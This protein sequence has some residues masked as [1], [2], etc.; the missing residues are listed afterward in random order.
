MDQE[1]EE[2]MGSEDRGESK[3]SWVSGNAKWLII[4][5]ILL[6]VIAVGLGYIM[7]SGRGKIPVTVESFAP[8]GEIMRATNFTI[9]FSQD[10]VKESDVG[11]QLDSAPVVFTPTI[12]GKYRWIARNKLRFFPEVV[13]PPSTEYN[14]EILPEICAD[15]NTYLEGDR[16]YTFYTQRFRVDNAYFTFNLAGPEEGG[17]ITISAT[18]EFNYPVEPD[19]IKKHVAF[20]Y[21]SGRR[22]PYRVIT[23]YPGLIMELETEPVE[24]GEA[25]RDMQLWVSSRLLPVDGTL[26]SYQ[27]YTRAFVM[28]AK[29]EL[30]VE[31]VFVEQEGKYG[32]LKVRFSS[33]VAV[34]MAKRYISVDPHVD[35]KLAASY[36][37]IE[38]RGNFEAGKG[39]TIGINQELK[40]KDGSRLNRP[41]STR[42]VMQNMEP[43]VDFVSD[44]TYLSRTGN[45]NVGLATINMEKVDIEVQKVYA[46]NL[47]HLIN[48]TGLRGGYNLQHFGKRIY[49]EEI[50]IPSRPNEEVITPIN[51]ESYLVD[52]H[53]GIF[54][55]VARNVS[56]RWQYSRRW[57]MITDLGIT[58]KRAGGQFL[59][60]V[61]SLSSLEP[62][63]GAEVT[64]FSLNNQVIAKGFTDGGGVASFQLTDEVLKEFSTRTNYILITAAHDKDLSFV[65]TQRLNSQISTTDFDVTGQPYLRHGYDA[66]VYGER[67]IYRPGETAKLA[68]IVRG[69]NATVPPSFPLK[70]EILGPDNRIYDE[71][72]KKIN[73]EGACE[74]QVEFPSYVKTGRYTARALVGKD[75]EIGRGKFSVEEFMPDRIKVKVKTD[76][77]SY[78]LGQD[79]NIY[80]EAL[81]LFGPPAAGRRVEAQAEIASRWFSSPKWRSFIFNDHNKQFKKVSSNMGKATLDDQGK[82]KYVLKTQTG[83]LPPSA[84][85][86]NVAVTVLEPGGRAVTGYKTVDIHPYSHYAGLRRTE[87]GYAEINKPVEMEFVVV[88]QKGESTPGRQCKV[89]CYRV[90]WQSILR[91]TGGRRGY[92]YVSE[93][94]EDLVKSLTV[95]SEAAPGKFEFTPEQYGEYRIEIKDVESNGSASINFY[96]SG[97]GYAP[98]AMDRPERLE[99]DL[100][101]A[102]YRPGEVIKAQIRSPFAGKLLLTVEGDKIYHH[103]ALMMDENTATVD[104]PVLPEYKPNV[105]ISASVIRST[106]SLERHAPV[107]AFGVVPLP[108]D[109]GDNK[110]S[111][112]LD[113]PAEMRP[114]QPLTVSFTVKSSIQDRASRIKYLTIAAVDEGICQLTNFQT[115]DPFGHFFG[116][117]RLEVQSFD[118]YSAVLPEVE[119]ADTPSSA[120]GD[121]EAQRRKRVS[122]ISVM[123]VKP[124]A[125]WSGLVKTD[126]NGRGSVTFDVPQFNGTLRIMAVSFSGDQFGSERKDIKVFDPI[127]LTPTFPRFIAGGDR[128][129]VPVSI[130]NGTG[131]SD[132]FEVRLDIDGPVEKP[133]PDVQ[134]VAL[135][136]KKEGQVIFSLKAQELMGKV[137]FSLSAS[138]GGESTAMIT[139]VPLRPAAPAITLSGSGVVRAGAEASF[140]FPGD[141]VPGT[142]EFDLTLSS[143][144]AMEFAGSLQYLLRYPYGC[145][146][147]TT[148]RLFPLLY[149]NDMA[150]LVEPELFGAQSADYFIQEGLT[151]L[152]N[153]QMRDGHFAYWP[154]G[155]YSNPWTSIY[156]SHFF[157]EARKAGYE[158]PDRIYKQMI[159]AL[160]DHVKRSTRDNWQLQTK[161]YAC[162]VLAM[163]GRPDK[164]TMF[165]LKNNELDNMSDYSQFQLAGAFALSGDINTARSLFPSTVTPQ[166]VKRETGRNFNSSIRA[167]AIMLNSLAEA[168]PDHPAVPKLIKSLADAAA[169][170]NRWYTTQDNAFAFLALGKIMRKQP[171]GKYTGTVKLDGESY[172]DFDSGDHQFSDKGWAGKKITLDVQGTGNCYYYWTAFGIP[173]SPDIKEFDQELMVRRRYLDKEGKAINYD[174]VQQGDMIIAQITAKALT[175]DMDN[176]IIADLLPAG[177]EIENPRLESRAGIP[178]IKGGT[179]PAYM[180]IRDDRMLL[181]VNLRR[182]RERKFHY[183]LRAVTVGEF[184]LPPVVAEA[185]YDPAKL[186]VANSGSVKVI[187]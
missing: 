69:P 183:A 71:F 184:I 82:H 2:S 172:A 118:I 161:A 1:K 134:V 124:V 47:I 104:V 113:T 178:W 9:E 96:A 63:S 168:D 40:G 130:F 108:V 31:G 91:R 22:I 51:M 94:Q 16:K 27:D 137:T 75:N 26:G 181:F 84:L 89:S 109:C 170:S 160:Q 95:T 60:W 164:S 66:F 165:Y 156:V 41:F 7:D 6:A 50:T 150:K 30:K 151:R 79:I 154:G 149:F 56:K 135:D 59:V 140:T 132:Q 44:G 58:I 11:V 148:S 117:K 14:A 3:A 24:R 147:Q 114:L 116:K 131:K 186:S 20:T 142:T 4:I 19:E 146:E 139:E 15:E 76:L 122:P 129:Q 127:V 35:H 85:R 10:M 115:P 33:P 73:E 8:G 61:N 88:D 21:E 34:D 179:R 152:E 174:Q 13:L 180:D 128:F 93:K 68:V 187:Q 46:N 53:T 29:E 86:G 153:M 99:I 67:D 144:P 62:I 100:D 126:A 176:I 45:L 97:W 36:N 110:L 55:V 72:R 157:V 18:V 5:G 123:R 121:A 141:W 163:A 64:L 54:T 28:R 38:L 173:V 48:T 106:Q 105:Y 145:A 101:K 32:Y 107:R 120:A 57:V 158:I 92:R 175:E 136:S 74:F 42:V 70:M 52:E 103:E 112:V 39:Y 125:M 159:K 111:I 119:K 171:P 17:K 43:S 162:Y 102:A 167:K 81:N 90:T 12:P 182:Q 77:E 98:W 80:V 133:Q 166:E 155:D 87:E 138:G 25:D 65:E 143:F 78:D 169:K 177:F 37:Y 185:M 23:Q 83:I 49:K